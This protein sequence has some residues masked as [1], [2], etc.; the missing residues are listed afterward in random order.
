M[1]ASARSFQEGNPSEANCASGQSVTHL[2]QGFGVSLVKKNYSTNYRSDISFL[3]PTIPIT[4]VYT[5]HMFKFVPFSS[6][7]KPCLIKCWPLIA[8]YGGWYA[9]LDF[10]FLRSLSSLDVH[11]VLASTAS[12]P[13]KGSLRHLTNAIFHLRKGHPLLGAYLET[14]RN[15]FKGQGRTEVGPMTLTETVRKLCNISRPQQ[16]DDLTG[17]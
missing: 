9:D 17:G 5:S 16:I 11:C 2:A 8:Q 10:V 15:K 7:E 14:F 6:L 4:L 12:S 1:R 3:S 13:R